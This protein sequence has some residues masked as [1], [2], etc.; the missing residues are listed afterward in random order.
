MGLCVSA[1]APIM[2]PP[3]SY[4]GRHLADGGYRTILPIWTAVNMGATKVLAISVSPH[5]VQS[6]TS[7]P[8]GPLRLLLR[9]ME[10]LT[11]QVEKDEVAAAR[12]RLDEADTPLCRSSVKVVLPQNI[13]VPPPPNFD[14]KTARRLYDAGL[15]DARAAFDACKTPWEAKAYEFTDDCQLNMSREPRLV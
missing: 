13:A 11:L 2:V 4:R 9:W 8:Y 14:R 1:S 6:L 12:L 15:C 10:L 7:V 3:M 5:R